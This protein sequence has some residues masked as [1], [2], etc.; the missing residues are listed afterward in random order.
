[1]VKNLNFAF[2]SREEQEIDVWRKYD[3]SKVLLAQRKEGWKESDPR[4]LN[5]YFTDEFKSKGEQLRRLC[6]YMKAW[7]D[8]QWV[9]GGPSSI[10]LMVL[11]DKFSE[12][13]SRDDLALLVVLDRANVFFARNGTNLLNPTDE[14]EVLQCPDDDVEKLIE[15]IDIFARDLRSSIHDGSISLE[16]AL[17]QIRNNVGDRFPATYV[18]IERSKPVVGPISNPSRP[19]AAAIIPGCTKKTLTDAEIKMLQTKAPG[20]HYDPIR[21]V[22]TGIITFCKEYKG[23]IITDLYSIEVD[24]NCISPDGLPVVRETGS[25]IISLARKLGIPPVDLHIVSDDGQLCMILPELVK[26]RSGQA[27]ASQGC[28]VWWP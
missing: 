10:Y 4:K 19:F 24:L 22:L 25:R 12:A 1:M 20:L 11:V 5:L 23:E 9:D 21:N 28:P 6:R 26:E 2:E 15:Q 7:R 13:N 8:F 27:R 14:Q 3:V 17:Q 18:T 16:K